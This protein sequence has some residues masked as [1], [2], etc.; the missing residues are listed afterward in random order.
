ML[1]FNPTKTCDV[2]VIGGGIAGLMAAIGAADQGAHVI[3]AEKANTRR[4]GS[5]ATG[6]DHFQCYFPEYHG[7]DIQPIL[8]EMEEAQTGGCS[9]RDLMR[10]FAYL[11]EARIREWDSWGIDM[12]PTGTWEF[13]GHA[14]PNRPRIWLKYAGHN[15]KQVLTQQALKRGVQILNH[16]TL[17]E[18]LK[19]ESGKV[20]G[21]LCVDISEDEP[22]IQL[23]NCKSMILC[24][25]N[26]TRLYLPKTGGWM[27]NTANCPACTGNGRAAAYRAG[28][29][30]I[31]LD[32]PHT[33]AGPKYFNR[34]GK[35][36]WIGVYRDLNGKPMGPFVTQPTKELGDITGDIWMEMFCQKYAQGEPVFMD[37]SMTKP[38]DLEYMKWGLTNEGNTSTLKHMEEEGIDLTQH[39]VEFYQFEPILVGRGVE[40]DEYAATNIPGLYAAGEETGNFRADIAGAAVYGK[41]AGESAAEY[42]SHLD[43]PA[44]VEDHP[45]VREKVAFYNELFSRETCSWSATW[46][47]ANIALGQLMNDY[48]GIDV[49]SEHLYQVGMTYLPRL[50]K[51]AKETLTCADS[52]EFL[53]C[54]EV[55]DLMELGQLLMLCG[56]ERKESRGKHRRVDFPFTNPLLNNRFLMIQN[57]DGQHVLEWRDRR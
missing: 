10:K 34:C 24:T 23:I 9:D 39:M 51:K 40:V 54:L 37:C 53:R 26:T 11:T 57:V 27:F 18:I 28:A 4:S 25:G 36:T 7:E 55:L 31:N 50:Q 6:N 20:C 52:H 5:G 17:A 2:L 22:S 13:T 19:D 33:H 1:K 8:R 14:K 49:R 46:K 3:V 32:L 48:A 44:G 42:S 12:K 16:T 15:Q 43:V 21:G 30:L 38:E 29:R 41:V 56:N 45:V 35:A 47:E